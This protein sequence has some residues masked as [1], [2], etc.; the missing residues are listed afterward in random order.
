MKTLLKQI[1]IWILTLEARIVLFRYKP[2]ILVVTGTVGKTSTKDAIFAVFSTFSYSR[3]SEKSFNSEIGV[4]LAILDLPTAWNNPLGWIKNI[5]LGLSMIILP[6]HYPK[7]LV[8]EIGTD[9]PHDVRHIARWLKP[10]IVV[11]TQFSSVPVHVEFFDSPEEVI[12]EEQSIALSLKKDGVLIINNDDEYSQE[13]RKKVDRKSLSFGLTEKALVKASRLEVLYSED[14]K[15]LGI[16]FRADYE[17]ASIPVVVHGVLG[18][19]H[20][21][22]I[23]AAI[24]AGVSKG[25]NV[26]KMNEVFNEYTPPRG[27]M[28]ILEGKQDTILIDDTYNSSPI[29]AEKALEALASLERR[30]QGRKIAVLGDMRELGKY[31][32][33]EHKHLGEIAGKS[34][35]VVVAVGE[36]SEHISTGAFLTDIKKENV[37]EFDTSLQAA[38]FL[39]GYIKK[40]DTILLKGSQSTRMEKAVEVLM[41]NPEEKE[42]LLVRQ[43]MEWKNR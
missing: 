2:K 6:N 3:K 38:D 26:V 19:Q 4:P 43:D 14:K 27:R 5:L 8:L 25:V 28:S 35:D 36:H 21:Y 33:R 22:P 18:V 41:K 7:W 29:A 20:V 31:S 13:L 37:Y 17:G 15:P 24:T 16:R 34:A 9:R 1:I 39:S 30:N 12:L 32:A 40:N 11:A 10:D 23:L 42:A